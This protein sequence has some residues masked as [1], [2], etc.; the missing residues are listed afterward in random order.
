MRESD[1]FVLEEILLE[2]QYELQAPL[3]PAPT[4]IDAGANIGVAALWFLARNPGAT[5]YAFEPES[6]NFGLLATNIG[7]VKGVTI[8]RVAVG[9]AA[10]VVTLHPAAHGAMH[11]IKTESGDAR[12]G[13]QVPCIRLD[14]YLDQRAIDRIDVLKIDVEGSE[15]DVLRGLGSRLDTVRVIVGEMHETLVDEAEFYA[16]LAARGF[17]RVRHQYYGSGHIDHVHVFEAIRVA[18]SHEAGMP[19]QTRVP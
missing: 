5:L 13:V 19:T 4:I 18:S 11:S 7:S 14:D 1:V 16:F 6:E 10:A 3:P 2:R 12:A 8:E 17:H 9:A 15:L